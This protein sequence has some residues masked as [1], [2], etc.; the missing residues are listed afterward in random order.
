MYDSFRMFKEYV[1]HRFLAVNSKGHGVHSPFFFDFITRVLPDSGHSPIF[2]KPE[3]YRKALL[4]DPTSFERV[5]MGAGSRGR[6]ELA[7]VRSRAFRS[8]QKARWARLLYRMVAHHRPGP[9]P[10]IGT[11]FGVTTEYLAAADPN[12]PVFTLEGDPFVARRAARQFQADGFSQIRLIEGNFD[13][14][15]SDTLRQVGHVG[16]VWLDGNHRKEP[17]LRYVEQ[18]I[19]HL[20]NDSMLVLDDI[21]WSS[22]MQAAWQQIQQHPAVTGTIDLFQLGVVLFRREF[23]QKSHIRL[24]Y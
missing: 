17:T 5:E 3:R 13:D 19:G 1:S 10:E 7:T 14:T 18:L 16:F 20:H 9:I 11:S 12:V 23:R 2:D 21:Y 8:L 6:K 22:S 24:H 15:L 4:S